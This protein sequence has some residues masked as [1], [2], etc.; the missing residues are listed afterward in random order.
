MIE[1]FVWQ[2]PV[3]QLWHS[4]TEQ[5]SG[6]E[7]GVPDNIRVYYNREVKMPGCGNEGAPANLDVLLQLLSVSK[8]DVGAA[9]SKN[10]S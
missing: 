7:S 3:T 10:S 1:S 4:V 8:N 2:F 9:V 6:H 5:E